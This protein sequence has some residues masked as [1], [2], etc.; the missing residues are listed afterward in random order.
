MHNDPKSHPTH[1]HRWQGKKFDPDD[2]D[3]FAWDGDPHNGPRCVD[4]GFSFCVTCRPHAWASPC[5]GA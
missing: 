2:T 5:S 3:T 4:C 1:P